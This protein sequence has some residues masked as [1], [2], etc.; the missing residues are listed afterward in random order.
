[1]TRHSQTLDEIQSTSVQYPATNSLSGQGVGV[2]QGHGEGV[3]VVIE[4]EGYRIQFS[5]HPTPPPSSPCHSTLGHW[6]LEIRLV[7][8][9]T[10]ASFLDQAWLRAT[11]PLTPPLKLTVTNPYQNPKSNPG[12]GRY[13]ARNRASSVIPSV[14]RPSVVR[15]LC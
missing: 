14:F 2:G 3:G 13:V 10:V 5:N 9:M 7:K 11:S 4:R 15:S 6:T 8:L 12:E 1:M